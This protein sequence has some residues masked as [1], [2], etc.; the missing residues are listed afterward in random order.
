MTP[1]A[2]PDITKLLLAWSAGDQEALKH[3]IPLVEAELNR[4]AHRQM[5]REDPGHPL[6]TSA[7]VN[8]AYFRLVN[9][10]RV[11]WQNRAHFFGIS[12]TIMRQILMDIGR[13]RQRNGEKT[14]LQQSVLD[15]MPV[16]AQGAS[17]DLVALDDALKALAKL[18]ELK[19]R[20]VELRFFGGLTIEE[21]AEVLKL[22]PS[23]IKREWL[24]AKA[25]LYRELGN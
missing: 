23:K 10:E 7:L 18:D 4:I 22:H 13:R 21:T 20:I 6:E 15:E 8:E 17:P 24:S 3:L 5:R 1:T 11:N 12:A 14:V 2:T 16:R 19:G 9:I 25:W